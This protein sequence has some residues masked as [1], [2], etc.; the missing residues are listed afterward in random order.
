MNILVIDDE[1]KAR[2]LLKNLIQSSSFEIDNIYEAEDLSSGVSVIKKESPKLVFLDIEMPNEQGTEIFKYFD[3]NEVDFEL[4]FTTAYSEYALQAFEMNAV[5]YLL[6][7]IRPKRLK[8]VIERV[9]KSFKKED[10]QMRLEELKCTLKTNNFKKIGLPVQDGFQFVPLEEIVHLEAD[11]MYTKVK[12]KDGKSIMVSKPLRFF[13]HLLDSK[14]TF[15]RP[16]RSHIVNL[17]FLKQYVR[18]DGS[19]IVMENEDIVPVSKDKKEE[20]LEL[21]SSI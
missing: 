11:G 9:Q 13:Q 19:Y 20:F 2:S 8:E 17:T 7:P 18:K 10:I 3:E 15:Y 5:D 1:I 12:K 6:K 4:V 16:H 21:V 14:T